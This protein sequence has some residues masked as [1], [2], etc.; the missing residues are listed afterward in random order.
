MAGFKNPIGDHTH[1]VF[2]VKTYKRF[3]GNVPGFKWL[4]DF[5]S[6]LITINFIT[7][8]DWFI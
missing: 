4:Y 5:H 7:E 8:K 1:T 2:T 6:Y 3:V